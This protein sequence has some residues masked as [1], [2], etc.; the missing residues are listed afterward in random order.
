LGRYREMPDRILYE[1]L[2][3]AYIRRGRVRYVMP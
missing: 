3:L 1:K 2:G